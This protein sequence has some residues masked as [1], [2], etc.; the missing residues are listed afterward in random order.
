MKYGKTF[1]KK[2]NQIK[3][4]T[5]EAPVLY[6]QTQTEKNLRIRGLAVVW[7]MHYVRDNMNHATGTL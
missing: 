4:C 3:R 7:G 6:L 2:Q 1:L 5:S